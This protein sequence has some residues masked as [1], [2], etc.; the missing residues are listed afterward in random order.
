MDDPVVIVGA[1]PV[2]M[3]LACDLLQQGVAV[4]LID[5]ARAHSAHSRATIV[6]PRLLE[7]LHRTGV[8][9]RLVQSGHR[10]DGVAYFSHGRRLGTAW[11]TRLRDTPYPF[12]VGIAQST[13][14]ELIEDRLTE[15]GGK[16]ER[17]TRL[18]SL[19]ETDAPRPAVVLEGPDGTTEEIRPP[20]LVGA[21]GSHSTVRKLLGIS[22]SGERLDVSFAITDAEVTGDAPM[23]VVSYCYTEHGS[24]ALGP[25]GSN[26]S[27]VAVSVPHP[28]DDTPPSREFF[29]SVI[30]QR[31]PGRNVLGE[32]RF[33]TT[34]RVHARIADRFRVGRCLLAGDS[35]HIMSPAGAQ[36]MNTGLQDAV[37]LGW[38][39][40]GVV[41][42][43][44]PEEAL[45]GYQRERTAAAHAVALSTARQTR[46]GMFRKPAQI[47][48]RDTVFRTAA[49]TGVV[50]RAVAP[51]LAQT[52][53]RY[54]AAD[55]A[56]AAPAA[57]RGSPVPGARLPVLPAP[58]G[59][60][61]PA[62]GGRTA[63]WV[64]V[65]ADSFTA[66]LWHG[67][68]IPPGWDGVVRQVRAAAA[69]SGTPVVEVGGGHAALAAA[70]GAAPVIAIVRPDGH[71]LATVPADRA[72]EL[73]DV[74]EA[75][76]LRPEPLLAPLAAAAG[77]R[78][79]QAGDE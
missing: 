28:Q 1:G 49:A 62:A 58:G 78:G 71:L 6:W 75:L 20:W 21:D 57:R 56:G 53:V 52:T 39:L 23:N 54:P 35:A 32:L 9:D 34:F 67:R 14:E 41:R 8:A 73:P 48:L 26:I 43:T 69:R 17:G 5:A 4:R 59:G 25:L 31:A 51:L 70:L 77:V 13:T 22:F 61:A 12:A 65:A 19:T 44:L 42:G 10:V 60:S 24:L 72:A 11:M 64:H 18:T 76:R 45:D 68:R 33:S 55:E 63:D 7:L 2:G 30:D 50:Q 29:Q 38:R 74:L 66:L 15:L 79:G 36:G 40:G 37:N 46:W 47:A 16:I 27:R 3:L